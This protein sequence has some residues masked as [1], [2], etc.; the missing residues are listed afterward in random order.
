M[1]RDQFLVLEQPAMKWLKK[2]KMYD[3]GKKEKGNKR[4][5][6]RLWDSDN[7]KYW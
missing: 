3:N 5:Y 6:N 7:R 2:K 1:L 4:A